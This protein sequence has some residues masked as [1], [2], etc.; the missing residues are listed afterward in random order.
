[1]KVRAQHPMHLDLPDGRV[2]HVF[3]S[4]RNGDDP[5]LYEYADGRRV[6]IETRI[7]HDLEGRWFWLSPY[8]LSNGGVCIAA[9]SYPPPLCYEQAREIER[10]ME[11]LE[12]PRQL[13]ME[14]V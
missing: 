3:G 7:P 4:A 9:V 14:L 11:R 10:E 1:M 13:V 6:Q 12:A 5:Q 2:T 8:G